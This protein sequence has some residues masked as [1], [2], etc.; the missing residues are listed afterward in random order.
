MELDLQRFLRCQPPLAS[1]IVHRSL[2]RNQRRGICLYCQHLQQW[3]DSSTLE[4]TL[5]QLQQASS[6]LT[7][8]QI[9]SIYQL[10][11]DFT[12][13]RLKTEQQLPQYGAHLWSPTLK[14]AQ[15][16]VIYYKLWLSQ[17]KTRHTIS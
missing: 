2:K 12:N 9:L 1:S 17:Y 5:T 15:H 14:K 7:A 8:T 6:P 4:D 3:L 11:Q 10:E 13:A 16:Q